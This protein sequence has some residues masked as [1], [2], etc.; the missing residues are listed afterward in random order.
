MLGNDD[1]DVPN[2]FRFADDSGMTNKLL[3][4]NGYGVLL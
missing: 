4:Q 3:S 2:S 1:T